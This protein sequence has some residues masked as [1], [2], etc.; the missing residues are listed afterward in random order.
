MTASAGEEE[1]M[2]EHS[3]ESPALE[4]EVDGIREL[5]NL[6]PRWWVWLFN[7]TIA[8]SV[9]YLLYY[10]V[11]RVGDL[12]VA[13]YEKEFKR[14]EEIKNA[15]IAKF[16]SN[17][18]TLAPIQDKAVIGDGQR[19]YLTYCAPC[20]RLDGGGQVGPNLCDA[21]WIHGSNYVD[22]VRTIIEG[23][24]SKGMLTWRGILQ[25]DQ[26]QAVGSYIYTLRG[27]NPKNP[28]PAENTVTVPTGPSVYE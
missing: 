8:F 4:H 7:L 13:E 6:L 14:G 16:E 26:I 10:H 22:N 3:Q 28:K 23:V 25:P 19:L 18:A 12:Q 24:P 5:D 20:H 17:V 11:F 2:S 27:S 21:Y 15:S 1:I 9:A